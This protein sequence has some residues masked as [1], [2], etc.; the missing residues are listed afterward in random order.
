[1]KSI[2]FISSD[3]VH[4]ARQQILLREL[5]KYFKILLFEYFKNPKMGIL[6][7]TINI[8]SKFKIWLLD[9]KPDLVLVR[10]DRYELLG[11]AMI[12]AYSSIPIAHI[13]GGDLS[14]AIDNK[15]RHAITQLADIHFATNKESFAR[16]INA[17][18]DPTWTFD[19]GSLDVEYAKSVSVG[20]RKNHIVICY[21]PLKGENPEIIEKAV[22][23]VTNSKIILI[24]SNKDS[25]SVYGKEEYSSD[26]YIKLIAE[27]RCLIGNSSSFIKEASIFGT[28][29]INIGDRQKNRL[30]PEN[31]IDCP[32]EEEQIKRVLK[33]QL[34]KKYK[35]SY[36]Y[37]KPNTSKKITEKILEFLNS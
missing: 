35:P 5:G 32:L 8:T 37:Y 25:G 9:N 12:T 20:P 2:A 34:D 11:P 10:G 29:V 21:H 27:A 14:G 18:T 30:K 23:G 4:L 28:P 16:L 36:I 26:E 33:I 1:M 31:V 22:R 6:D 17:G 15:V 7:I 19:F 13:E 3:R 24:K